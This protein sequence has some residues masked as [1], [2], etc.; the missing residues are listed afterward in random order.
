LSD[1]LQNKFGDNVDVVL[2]SFTDLVFEIKKGKVKISILGK[3]DLK[4]FDL[5]YV[6][7]AGK[8][9]FC[10]TGAIC[11]YL[12]FHKVRFFDSVL[13]RTGYSGDKLSANLTLA[14]NNFPIIPTVFCFKEQKG[15][16]QSLA[17]KKFGLPIIAKEINSQR[18]EGT[19]IIKRKND[20]R[21]LNEK[22]VNYILQKFIPIQEEFRLMVLGNRVGI[23]M[24][25]YKRDYSKF[26]VGKYIDN[27][28]SVFLKEEDFSSAMKNL[29]VQA[30][31][32]LELEI[33]GVDIC[34]EKD[35]GRMWLIEVNRGPGLEPDPN[36]TPEYWEVFK[37]FREE[38]G[39]KSPLVKP[40]R[41]RRLV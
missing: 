32:V 3:I 7:R 26:K 19:F 22:G 31:K 11:R 2:S 10:F 36:T 30:S 20:F 25:K 37:F 15:L 8:R 28:W 23:F 24:R 38:L 16:A 12:D 18:L 40:P 41:A 5:V 17:V 29:A 33:S 39:I 14:V 13:R 34:I 6:R 21:K 27:K 35:N 4:D 9:F 1:Y